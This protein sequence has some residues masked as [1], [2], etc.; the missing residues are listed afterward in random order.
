M[1]IEDAGLY[2]AM[3][4][5]GHSGSETSR[6]AAESVPGKRSRQV[7]DIVAET[8]IYGV[9]CK[10]LQNRLDI[11][12]GAASGALTRLHRAGYITRLTEARNG[13]QVYVLSDPDV[14]LERTTSPYRPNAAYRDDA[15]P[16]ALADFNPTNHQI[17]GAMRA[18]NIQPYPG[19]VDSQRR[20]IEAL[21][22][23]MES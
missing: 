23:E 15:K 20:F 4:S 1:G 7:H 19:A 2:G 3:Q 13:Q 22:K 9:T 10:E 5:H 12:H 17:A 16:M 11:G 6:L 14:V 18:I 21:K 8:H